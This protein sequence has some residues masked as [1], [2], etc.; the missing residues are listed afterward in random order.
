[1]TKPLTPAQ[2]R[3]VRA[4]GLDSL[5]EA[6]SMDFSPFEQA[7][8]FVRGLDCKTTAEWRAWVASG[9]RPT[10]IPTNPNAVYR[11]KGWISWSDWLGTNNVSNG[12]RQFRPFEQAREYARTLGLK[13]NYEW[14]KW[15]S[16]GRRPM[17][18]PSS[19]SRVYRPQWTGYGDWLGTGRL[20][21]REFRPFI[22]AREFARRLGLKGIAEWRIW[23]NSG[24]RPHDIPTTPYQTYEQEW[25]SWGDWLG[26]NR[27][28]NGNRKCRPF[29]EAREFVRS[30][31][32]KNTNEWVTWAASSKRPKDI[33]ACPNNVYRQ[34]WTNWVDWLGANNRLKKPLYRPFKQ[35][36]EFAQGL[37]LSSARA[38]NVW[39][40]SGDRPA[41][42][43]THPYTA[44][45]EWQSWGDWLG[46][47]NVVGTNQH[48]KGLK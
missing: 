34:E 30:L 27:V 39:S 25:T 46:T 35:A 11:H 47:G 4:A 18:I 48:K 3:I 44:Y 15:S 2:L 17:D 6:P 29:E 13:S 32:L 37:G 43:P 14:W 23:C 20:G 10:D 24:N 36:R 21:K 7:R 19:P 9:G 26:T 16:S 8:E 42:I 33:P 22:Q 1:M 31:G 12:K 40:K 38:W 45:E 41:D 5:P 28:S